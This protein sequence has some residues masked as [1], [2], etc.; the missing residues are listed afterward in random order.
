MGIGEGVVLHYSHME[1]W[2]SSRP[3]TRG[4]WNRTQP[5]QDKH[6]SELRSGSSTK[7]TEGK[8]ACNG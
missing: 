8:R 5:E 7:H 2:C 3:R 1:H 4:G 6:V